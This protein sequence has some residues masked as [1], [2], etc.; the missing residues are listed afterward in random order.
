MIAHRFYGVIYEKLRLND[1]I[2]RI[3]SGFFVESVAFRL[4]YTVGKID[5]SGLRI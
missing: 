1:P 3:K 5:W 2:V 4:I